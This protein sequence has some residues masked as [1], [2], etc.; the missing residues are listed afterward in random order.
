MPTIIATVAAITVNTT[1]IPII[2]VTTSVMNR[3]L[4][5]MIIEIVFCLFVLCFNTNAVVFISQLIFRFSLQCLFCLF[6][7]F[8]LSDIRHCMTGENG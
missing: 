8:C 4:N 2:A 7:S 6:F 1:T 5:A 3:Q